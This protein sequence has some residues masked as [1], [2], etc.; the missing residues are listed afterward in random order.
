M[1]ETVIINKISI[2]YLGG[3]QRMTMSQTSVNSVHCPRESPPKKRAEAML[4]F[5]LL[6]LK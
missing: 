6:E 1:R 4:N 2:F 3:G 5:Q